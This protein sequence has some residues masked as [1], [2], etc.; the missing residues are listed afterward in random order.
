VVTRKGEIMDVIGLKKD[1][2]AKIVCHNW[3]ACFVN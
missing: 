3:E 2:N 1:H